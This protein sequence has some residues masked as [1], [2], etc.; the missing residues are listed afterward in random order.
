MGVNICGYRK[1]AV[2]E[3]FLY[4]F[5]RYAIG[6]KKRR[7]TM[8]LQYNNAKSENPVK[9]RVAGVGVI[10]FHSVFNQI[11]ADFLSVKSLMFH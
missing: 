11:G 3:P 8:P 4:L 5:E 1:I 7:A 2:S 10:Y 9:S 6:E